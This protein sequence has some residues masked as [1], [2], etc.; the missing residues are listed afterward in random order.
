M[1]GYRSTII[2]CIFICYF[3]KCECHLKYVRYNDKLFLESQNHMDNNIGMDDS[4]IIHIIICYFYK[5]YYIWYFDP[6]IQ[7]IIW[8]MI[9][10]CKRRDLSFHF[11]VEYLLY[12]RLNSPSSPCSELLETSISLCIRPPAYVHSGQERKKNKVRRG[13]AKQGEKKPWERKEKLS[14]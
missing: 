1:D 13:E 12:Q 2:I 3:Y 4:I 7:K 10:A 6:R 8:G 5:R 9:T 14:A 11:S